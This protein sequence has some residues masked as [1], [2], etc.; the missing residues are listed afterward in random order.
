M[1]KIFITGGAGFVARQIIATLVPGGHDIVAAA[2]EQALLR[3]VFPHIKI[4]ESDFLKDTSIATW[5]KRLEDIDIVINCVGVLQHC[6][7]EETWQ[8]H[9]H[10][11]KLLFDACVQTGV[12]KIIQISALGVDRQKNP[13]CSSKL[14][15]EDYL[16]QLKIDSTIIR[17]SLV[18]GTGSYG[19]SSLFRGLAGLPF[20]IPLPGNAQQKLQPIHITDL[21]KMVAAS[22]PVPGKVILPGVGSEQLS[23]QRI[24]NLTREWLGFNKAINFKVPLPLI[25]AVAILGNFFRKTPINSTSV[26]MMQIDNVAKEEEL[27]QLHDLIPFQPRGFEEALFSQPSQ[28]QDRWHAR[29]YFLKPLARYGTA[30]LW[31]WTAVVS[32]FFYPKTESYALLSHMGVTPFFQP[33]LLYS[34]AL[35]DGLLGFS[36]LFGYRLRLTASVQIGLIIIYSVLITFFLPVYWLE[37]FAPIAKNIPLIIL[38]LVIVALESDR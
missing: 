11:P 31:I 16:Q 3:R 14:A 36:L 18:F 9:Y 23:L 1:S 7:P 35:L 12:K 10:T 21:A 6:A 8:I 27:K 29:L 4:I 24:L 37:P 17:P 15:A 26:R 38:T 13:Y 30:F 32:L 22:I 25:K 20:I 19:G 5:I 34:A 28:V 33:I 2:R